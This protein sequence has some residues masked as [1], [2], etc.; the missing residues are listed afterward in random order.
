MG[1]WTSAFT[2]GFTLV[3]FNL[4]THIP[5]LSTVKRYKVSQSTFNTIKKLLLDLSETP[6]RHAMVDLIF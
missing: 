6:P 4:L 2:I 5:A 1:A 3:S